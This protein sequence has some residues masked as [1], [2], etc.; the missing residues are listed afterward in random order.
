M[1]YVYRSPE[2][3]NAAC[4]P[5]TLAWEMTFTEFVRISVLKIVTQ[6]SAFGEL[7]AETGTWSIWRLIV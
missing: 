3:A 6:L 2:G 7:A 4:L 1:C 5:Q